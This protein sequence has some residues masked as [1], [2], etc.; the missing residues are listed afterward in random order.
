MLNIP[1]EKIQSLPV[2]NIV[3]FIWLNPDEP[4]DEQAG[5]IVKIKSK[6]ID[7]LITPQP[8]V[9][10]M[11][12]WLTESKVI[13]IA[14]FIKLVK[15]NGRG[16]PFQT[17]LNPYIN[18]VSEV[19]TITTGALL[20][21]AGVINFTTGLFNIISPITNIYGSLFVELHTQ[22][23]TMGTA[24]LTAGYIVTGGCTGC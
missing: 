17:W 18:E 10:E 16:I 9:F 22:S 21:Q 11:K 3:S 2:G 23:G 6:D 24:L 5:W 12:H 14:F 13:I 8:I 15:N 7:E 20:V 4:R 19:H 1:F